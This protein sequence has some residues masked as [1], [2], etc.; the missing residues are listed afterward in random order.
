MTTSRRSFAKRVALALGLTGGTSITNSDLASPL[1]LMPPDGPG[2]QTSA[3]TVPRLGGYIRPG[4]IEVVHQKFDLVVVGGG[5]SGTCAA[6]SA[7]RNDVKVALVHERSTLGG[8]SSSE[9]NSTPRTPCTF[10]PWIKEIPEYWTNPHRGKGSQLGA[11]YRG[12]NEFALGLR[13][14]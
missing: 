13:T 2:T 3:G 12:V 7:A 5:I 11:V 9:V 4:T 6:I 8:N 10:S 14:L 1:G